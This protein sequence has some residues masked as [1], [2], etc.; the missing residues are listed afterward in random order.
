MLLI[1][2][3]K[4]EFIWVE[5]YKNT[6]DNQMPLIFS[7]ANIAFDHS[8]KLE[9]QDVEN[10]IINGTPSYIEWMVSTFDP[11]DV[12]IS[13][14]FVEFIV[15]YSMEGCKQRSDGDPKYISYMIMSKHLSNFMNKRKDSNDFKEAVDAIESFYNPKNI[16]TIDL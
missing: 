6:K 12:T 4:G 7:S 13:E 15:K 10:K 5:C 14:S 9:V 11:N 3:K 1:Q 8:R 16:I 2:H